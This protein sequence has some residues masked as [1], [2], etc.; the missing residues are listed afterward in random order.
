MKAIDLNSK[1]IDQL[2]HFLIVGKIG[3]MPTDTIYGIVGLALNPK[4]VEEIYKI[5]KRSLDKP[6]IILISS[7]SDL[8]KFGIILTK[9]QEIFI[10]K[11]WPNSVSVILPVFSQRFNYLHR[12]KNKLAF[13][14]PENEKLL[15]ILKST[16]PLVAPSA[17]FEGE[18][19]AENIEAA[20]CYFGDNIS[21][22]LNE[23]E[24]KSKP[25]TI[26]ELSKG[27]QVKL[28]REGAFILPLG[29]PKQLL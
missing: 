24:I 15:Q 21:F 2:I 20:K 12:G 7:V 29:L 25:S 13:R 23:G 17:N 22:Y 19:N 27:G 9:N 14:M 11:I 28:V 8:T 5:K 26:I 1:Q 18:K 4:T 6:M 16:G 10:N 3:V